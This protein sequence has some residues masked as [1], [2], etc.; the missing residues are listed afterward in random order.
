M[1]LGARRSSREWTARGCVTKSKDGVRQDPSMNTTDTRAAARSRATRRLR[2]ITIGTAM[3]SVAATGALGWAAAATYNG[4]TAG[5]GLTAGVVTTTVSDGGT[6]TTAAT[7]APTAVATAPPVTTAIGNA[8]AST[9]G[10]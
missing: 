3:L 6:S 9:G 8:H 1:P 10:S 4:S 7:A 5:S 2:T